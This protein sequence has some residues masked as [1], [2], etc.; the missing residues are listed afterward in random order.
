MEATVGDSD[1]IGC[2]AFKF[3]NNNNNN[4]YAD[5]FDIDNETGVIT[6]ISP[7]DR[8]VKEQYDLSVIAITAKGDS[9][10]GCREKFYK[11]L[12]SNFINN[13]ELFLSA[14]YNILTKLKL[15]KEKFNRN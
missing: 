8:E 12:L 13:A 9:A 10:E 3:A 1:G 7:L 11:N 14:Y 15:D 2:V 4:Q 6:A 5:L